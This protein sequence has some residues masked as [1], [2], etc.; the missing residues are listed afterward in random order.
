MAQN[1]F[2]TREFRRLFEEW[3]K[4]LKEDGFEDAEDFTLK[5]PELKVW[6]SFRFKQRHDE[7]E[8]YFELAQGL[9]TGEFKFKT[10]VTRRVWELHSQGKSVREIE[11]ILEMQLLGYKGKRR[12]NVHTIILEIQERSGIKRE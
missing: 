6:H 2:E 3:N 7:R 5:D 9:L 4:R 12:S 8:T 1:P 10:D 11:G